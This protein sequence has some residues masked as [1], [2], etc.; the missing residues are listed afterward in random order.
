MFHHYTRSGKYQEELD[1]YQE[2]L[3]DVI[4]QRGTIPAISATGA[5]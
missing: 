4:R 1:E 5:W 2:E 3:A